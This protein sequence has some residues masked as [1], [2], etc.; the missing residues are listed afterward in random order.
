MALAQANSPKTR[1]E[2]ER[3]RTVTG[4]T[5]WFFPRIFRHVVSHLP[6]RPGFFL[7]R[8]KSLSMDHALFFCVSLAFFFPSPLRGITA[9][10]IARAAIITNSFITVVVL[11]VRLDSLF[12]GGFWALVRSVA[13]FPELGLRDGWFTFRITTHVRKQNWP[14]S[15]ECPVSIYYY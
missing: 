4:E 8:N 9:M 15:W 7:L 3:G 14:S 13:L 5:P 2:I 10:P 6:K 12:A 11:V 1:T